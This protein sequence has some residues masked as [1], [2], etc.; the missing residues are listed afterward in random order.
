[1]RQAKYSSQVQQRPLTAASN[2]DRQQTGL[3]GTTSKRPGAPLV[4][5]EEARARRVP[6]G[7][8]AREVSRP[9]A[10][11][12]AGIATWLDARE[13]SRGGDLTRKRSRV[14][15]DPID[16]LPQPFMLPRRFRVLSSD[17][18]HP[19]VRAWL[20]VGVLTQ[21]TAPFC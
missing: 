7:A 9:L 16:L 17:A 10:D 13:P 6:D 12:T 20:A 19:A 21:V 15:A 18:A 8:V 11:N 2:H 4:R 5:D 3:A 14:V 1:M